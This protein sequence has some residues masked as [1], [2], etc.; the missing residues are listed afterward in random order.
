MSFYNFSMSKKIIR[1]FDPYHEGFVEVGHFELILRNITQKIDE[2][3]DLY[4]FPVNV[5]Q[6]LHQNFQLTGLISQQSDLINI[7]ELKKEILNNTIPSKILI[8]L[9]TLIWVF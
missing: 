9:I 6:L 5:Y 3:T 2:Q 1:F 7:K 8:H 4:E